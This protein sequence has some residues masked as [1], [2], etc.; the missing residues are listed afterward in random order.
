MPEWVAETVPVTVETGQTTRDVR[1]SA[2]RGASLEVTVRWKQ[3]RQP[4]TEGL[5]IV[6]KAP[7][8]A[9]ARVDRNGLARLQLPPGKYGVS[10]SIKEGLA[11]RNDQGHCSD[12]PN[13]AR[14]LELESPITGVVRDPYDKPAPGALVTS[15]FPTRRGHN[16]VE[17]D[18]EGRYE[19]PLS[20]G[21]S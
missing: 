8:W 19:M 12:G 21:T 6:S 2:T 9:R 10:F 17:T 3:N 16:A 11:P 7:Y 13:E 1:L 18:S 5:I 14:R 15:A 4:V 20:P